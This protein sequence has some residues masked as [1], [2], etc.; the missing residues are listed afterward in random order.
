MYSYDYSISSTDKNII[1]QTFRI[2]AKGALEEYKKS[3]K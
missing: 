3:K 1:R 2:L